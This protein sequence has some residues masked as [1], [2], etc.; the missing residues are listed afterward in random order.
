MKS[1]FHH[2][3]FVFLSLVQELANSAGSDKLPEIPVLCSSAMYEVVE[4][5]ELVR[6]DYHPTIS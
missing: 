2:L 6:T 3:R 5:V 1:N 4:I